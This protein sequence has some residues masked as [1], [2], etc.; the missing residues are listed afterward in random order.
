MK[1]RMNDVKELM[2]V[3]VE[4]DW[5]EA[6]KTRNAGYKLILSEKERE[7]FIENSPTKKEFDK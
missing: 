7:H 4:E 1:M 3:L 5:L 6:P 2:Q